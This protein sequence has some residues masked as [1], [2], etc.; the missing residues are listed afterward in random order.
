MFLYC[1]RLRIRLRSAYLELQGLPDSIS[2]HRCRLKLAY[3]H[4]FIWRQNENFKHAD[5]FEK[6]RMDSNTVSVFLKFSL[7]SALSCIHV[8][9]PRATKHSHKDIILQM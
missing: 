8:G 2:L 9:A 5:S 6:T 3:A 4:E 1:I 7:V